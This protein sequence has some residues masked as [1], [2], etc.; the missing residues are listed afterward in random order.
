MQPNYNLCTCAL[1]ALYIT[2]TK[3]QHTTRV[4][5]THHETV[6]GSGEP[7]QIPTNEVFTFQGRPDK[8]G[9]TVMGIKRSPSYR[10]YW[11]TN[12]QMNDPYVSS[13]MPVKRFTFPLSNLHLNDNSQE[14][15]RSD[16]NFDKLYKVRPLL[17]NLSGKY[18]PKLQKKKKV[19]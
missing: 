2:I 9:L 6:G 15:P 14:R 18:L 11:S 13:I 4:M 17:D 8:W 3:C 7:L 10:D 12:F 1:F 5:A 19:S 16:P